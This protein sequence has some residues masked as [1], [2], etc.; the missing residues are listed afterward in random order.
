VPE[1]P[2][3]PRAAELSAAVA[4]ALA[5]GGPIARAL[6]GFEPRQAQLEM[7]DA[8]A[9]VIAGGGVLLAEAGT[10]TGKTLAY[11]VPA[12]LS[13]VRVLVSTGTKNL[14]EQIFYKDLPVLR[15]SLPVRFTATY[16]KGRANYL[17]LHRLDALREAPPAG[18]AHHVRI[19]DAWAGE[20]ATGDRAELE[21]LP[22]D[23][24]L[25]KEVAASN[26]NCIG[27]QCPRYG[28]CF[29]TKMRQR[30]AK[31]DLVIVNHHLLCADASVRQNNYGEVIPEC[32]Y[33][34][35]DE[36]HQLEDVA[37]QYFGI[38]VSNYRL[39]DLAH[40]T[41]RAIGSGLI[42]ERDRADELSADVDRLRDAA[43]DF[44]GVL[45]ML[46][47]DAPGAVGAENRVRIGP[48]QTEKVGEE[49]RSLLNAL[50][51]LEAD[52]ALA[53]DA[54]EDV[55]A[56]GRRAVAIRDE[57]KILLR[58]DDPG[59]VF[60]LE[61]RGRGTFLR[62]APV[63]V[64]AIIRQMLLDR[65]DTTV[66]TSATLTVDRS[67]DYIRSRL[68]VGHARE[69]RLDSEFDY[70]RQSILYLPKGLPDPR[71]PHFAG[72][73]ARAILEI[74]K[75]SRGR[76]FVLFTSYANLREVHAI[77]SSELEY[78]ILVQGTAPRSALLRDFKATPHAVL[79][80]TAS[81]WQ[82]VDVVGEALSCVIIDKLPFA[83]PGD[84]ITAARIEAIAARG[85]SAFGEYQIPL[86]ILSLQQGLG[87]LLRHRQDRGVLAVLDARLRTMGYGRRFLA[88]LPPAPVTH[89]IED[90][91]AFFAAEREAD[92]C[93]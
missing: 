38:A 83:S 77:A 51:A 80:A 68:G 49:G 85:G 46:R 72:A 11:L 8:V 65:M 67:F 10:G 76:A 39:D 45:Q 22:E 89:R 56:L 50:E 41:E 61:A 59:L 32:H 88:S 9:A 74:L 91:E 31:S 69:L 13:G 82:G 7:A 93:P 81:F 1:I 26:E 27:S 79:L 21:D 57:L 43:R 78:P 36:A 47:F 44:F 42:A 84:P 66:L 53:K 28:D 90:V 64:S 12:I 63:D 15:E 6:P 86:A 54:P 18:D 75:R 34:I 55:L 37:T 23:L 14:Q 60:Y 19:I 48:A 62:A 92:E 40:D 35:V 5:P 52:V 2:S 17:C 25:W 24:P 4:A 20:T 30:A 70:R 71:S 33:A 87:R 58:A 73:A 3:V 16:M 29:V